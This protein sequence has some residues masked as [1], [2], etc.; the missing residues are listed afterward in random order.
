MK[1]LAATL[2]LV[3]QC[4][5]W[6]AEPAKPMADAGFEIPWL[7]ATPVSPDASPLVPDRD[8]TLDQ[9]FN[10]D[11]I[12]WVDTSGKSDIGLAV[13][14]AGGGSY[15]LIGSTTAADGV[16][17]TPVVTPFTSGG[18]AGTPV[19][20]PGNTDLSSLNTIVGAVEGVNNGVRR[21]YV[22]GTYHQIGYPDTDFGV[23]CLDPAH[24][25]IAC[26]GFGIR[27]LSSFAFDRGGSKN[28]VPSAI[29]YDDLNA[30]LY[31]TGQVTTDTDYRV[32]VV[33]M[34]GTNGAPDTDWGNAT[35]TD[36]SFVSSF[37]FRTGGFASPF[38][39]VAG[40]TSLFQ[41]DVFV[42]GTAQVNSDGSDTDGFVMAID[43]VSGTGLD[44]EWNLGA[45]RRIFFD[46]G[47]TTKKDQITALSL[48][49]NGALLIA[50][51]AFG[52]NGLQQMIFGEL[53]SAGT[54]HSGYCGGPGVCHGP[55]GDRP[56]VVGIVERPGAGDVV[57]EASNNLGGVAVE[58][59][60]Q[61]GPTGTNVVASHTETWAST[62]GTGS[63]F[64]RSLTIDAN[65]R[66]LAVGYRVYDA[67]AG[68]YSMTIVRYVAADS[69]FGN[70]FGGKYK[71]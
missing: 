30:A 65:N 19:F 60:Y 25:F 68:D 53:T 46:L 51:E 2:F 14:D 40:A 43:A 39:I 21:I 71:D 42:A 44:P 45:P 70:G 55:L 31:V 16:H 57:V 33:R 24:A 9:T 12:E 66:V 38:A 47:T 20:Y 49:H 48:R 17:L 62:S 3:F 50:G 52:D 22:V 56:Y 18:F 64:A 61:L 6:G 59:A 10:Y 23:I 63:A 1:T 7:P 13:V 34:S 11:G 4:S 35:T 67:A 15:W 41:H 54:P 58:G 37:E 5:A 69:I 32:G 8:L 28:D 27:G 26:A 36:G 29:A